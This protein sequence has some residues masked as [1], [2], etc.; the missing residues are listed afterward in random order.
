[1]FKYKNGYFTNIRNGK[2]IT[3]SGGKDEEAQPIWVWNAYKG[4]H[5]SQIWRIAYLHKLDKRD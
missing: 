4:R 5:P 3:V 1:M 2:K